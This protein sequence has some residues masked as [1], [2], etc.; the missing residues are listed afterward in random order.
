MALANWL[1]SHHFCYPHVAGELGFNFAGIL[2]QVVGQLGVKCMHMA[3][4]GVYHKRPLCFEQTSPH[5]QSMQVLIMS[6][7]LSIRLRGKGRGLFFEKW[8]VNPAALRLVIW[9][10]FKKK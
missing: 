3:L 6:S 4:F 1:R 5:Y 8:L 7:V 2:S 9:L 10:L